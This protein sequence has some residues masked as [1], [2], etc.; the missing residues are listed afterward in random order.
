MKALIFDVDGTLAETEELHRRA[1]N[2]AFRL[3]GLNWEWDRDSYRDLLTITGGKERIQHHAD[4]M[5]AQVA[6]A[7]IHADKNR[8]FAGLTAQGMKLRPG[9]RHL[10]AEARAAGL[11]LAVAT[12]T[13]PENVEALSRAVFGKTAGQ[14]F[15]VIAAGDA[16]ARKKPAPDVYLLALDQLGVGA[17]EAVAFED[18]ANGVRAARAAGL[19]V[20]LSPGI[21]TRHEPNE[22]ASLFVTEFS[23]LGGLAGL[24]AALRVAAA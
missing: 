12:T 13:S 5:R 3:H 18:S 16:V 10:I 14:M 6:V 1:F 11:H 9:I 24:Q 20:V 23:H 2:A 15:D 8:L 17:G 19:R 4:V 21:Y 22:G 7:A